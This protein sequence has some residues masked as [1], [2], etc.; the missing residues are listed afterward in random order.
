MSFLAGKLID[1]E[2][3]DKY[4]LHSHSRME[5]GVEQP[6]GQERTQQHTA[7]SLGDPRVPGA[8]VIQSRPFA[9]CLP[10]AMLRAILCLCV[11]CLAIRVSTFGHFFIFMICNEKKIVF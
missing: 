2:A 3:K 8:A 11:V 6:D 1:K 10:P 5:P 4:N 7:E 9:P